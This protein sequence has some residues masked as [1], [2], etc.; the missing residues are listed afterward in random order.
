M[1]RSRSYGRP[2][3]RPKKCVASRDSP[4]SGHGFS[5]DA[6]GSAREAPDTGPDVNA[7]TKQNLNTSRAAGSLLD[8]VEGQTPLPPSPNP[9]AAPPP[10]VTA[11]AIKIART[12]AGRGNTV[13]HGVS[14]REA[15]RLLGLFW[16][17]RIAAYDNDRALAL[18][19]WQW[20]FKDALDHEYA[21]RSMFRERRGSWEWHR[22]RVK[23]Q[24]QHELAIT[25]GRRRPPVKIKPPPKIGPP[26]SKLAPGYR[27]VT[28][29]SLAAYEAQEARWKLRERM[30]ARRRER[31]QR[32]SGVAAGVA[33]A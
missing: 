6:D 15:R 18:T 17:R 16:G 27:Y 32:G 21:A 2:R 5:P 30:D 12:Y 3:G 31:A 23:R 14:D 10:E 11:E 13:L 29:E 19:H 33:G 24:Q 4:V 8:L 22:E 28:V 25:G 20:G 26:R 9:R 1:W 7:P